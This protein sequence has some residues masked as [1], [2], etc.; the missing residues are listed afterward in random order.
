MARMIAQIGWD[1][2]SAEV[3]ADGVVCAPRR[4]C[5][6]VLPGKNNAR[7]SVGISSGEHD[8]QLAENHVPILA[9]GMPMLLNALGGQI[10]HY[11]YPFILP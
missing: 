7:E 3:P 11:T 10:V 4:E 6:T 8:L 9:L 1:L 2:L 5:H